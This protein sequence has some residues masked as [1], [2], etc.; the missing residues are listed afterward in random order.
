MIKN[1][2]LKISN[3][4]KAYPLLHDFLR[5]IYCI[6][7]PGIRATI[8]KAFKNYKKITV[9][10]IGAMDGICADP[11]SS[12]LLNDPR[13]DGILVEPMQQYVDELERNFGATGRYKIQQVAIS[14][15]DGF[16]I[17]RVLSS[18]EGKMA[19]LR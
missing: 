2:P 4:L 8:L 6:F 7:Y 5:E 13:V 17:F 10:K 1:I 19:S 16:T 11:L 9:V 18:L 14:D 15:Y 12:F 3:Q